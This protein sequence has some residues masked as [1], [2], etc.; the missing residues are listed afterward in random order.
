ML[1]KQLEYCYVDS[2]SAEAELSF[3]DFK[4]IFSC[5]AMTVGEQD[6]QM[7]KSDQDVLYF[8]N[9]ESADSSVG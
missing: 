7:K 4:L 1:K 8:S 9:C 2:T 6:V 5:T 3:T